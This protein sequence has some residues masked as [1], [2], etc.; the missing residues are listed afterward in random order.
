MR[1]LDEVSKDGYAHEQLY[2]VYTHFD[3]VC[4]PTEEKCYVKA[5]PDAQ[6]PLSLN[7]DCAWTAYYALIGVGL[8]PYIEEVP[9]AVVE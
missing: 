5:S 7:R 2:R 8:M 6:A 1:G 3:D 9:P 4:E